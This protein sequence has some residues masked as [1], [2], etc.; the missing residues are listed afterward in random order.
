MRTQLLKVFALALTSLALTGC[1]GGEFNR[2]DD[3]PRPRR[4]VDDTR[5]RD[6]R[7]RPELRDRD[8]RDRDVRD[9]GAWRDRE[10]GLQ[11]WTYLGSRDVDFHADHD[12]IV[13]GGSHGKFRA[14]KFAVEGGDI[15]LYDFVIQVGDDYIRPSLRHSFRANSTSPAID[16]PGDKR[17]VGRVDFRYRSTDRRDGRATVSL[18]AR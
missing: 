3:E 9:R 1:P 17:T 12:T 13:V 6:D 16:L 2:R 18:Y 5:Y 15:E 10:P 4:D 11:G 7:D 14:V 8:V